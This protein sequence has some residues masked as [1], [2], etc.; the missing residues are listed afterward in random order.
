MST[1]LGYQPD[2]YQ[3]RAVRGRLTIERR[4]RLDRAQWERHRTVQVEV[5]GLAPC[6]P[7]MGLGSG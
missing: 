5:E 2:G 3:R 4:L 7:L 1:K 6:L